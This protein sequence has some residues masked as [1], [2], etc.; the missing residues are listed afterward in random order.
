MHDAAMTRIGQWWKRAKRAGYAFAQGASLHGSRPEYHYVP[1][2][3]RAFFWGLALPAGVFVASAVNPLAL[4]LLLAY[5]LQVL[6]IVAKGNVA[7]RI[8][9]W[10]ALFQVLGRFPEGFGMLNFFRDRL[11]GNKGVLIEY[12]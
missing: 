6:R 11:L 1:Q 2:A 12:K 3:R 9:W 7:S 8:T 4:I 10:H 5:P